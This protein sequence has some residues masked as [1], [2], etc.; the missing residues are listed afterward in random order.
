MEDM[1]DISDPVDI[2]LTVKR[3]FKEGGGGESF[4]KPYVTT[5]MAS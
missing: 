5:Q 3:N 2:S 1:I 4:V